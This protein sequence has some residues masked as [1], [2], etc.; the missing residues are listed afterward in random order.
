MAQ[1]VDAKGRAAARLLRQA[2]AVTT[3]GTIQVVVYGS[4]GRQVGLVIGSILDIVNEEIQ[5]KSGANRPGVLYTAVGWFNV[6]A[7]WLASPVFG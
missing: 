6:D 5:S 1:N 3:S 2:M 7:E 4:E